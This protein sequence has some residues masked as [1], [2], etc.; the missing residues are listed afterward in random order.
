MT[1]ESSAV[2]SVQST[3]VPGASGLRFALLIAVFAMAGILAGVGAFTFFYAKGA[4]YLVDDPQACVNCHIMRD[5][6][7]SWSH[8][9]HKAVASCNSCH[10]P[11]DFIGKYATKLENGYAHSRAFTFQD[12]KEPIEMRPVS[13]NIVLNNCL[14][15][16]KEMVSPIT[17]LHTGSQ[18]TL[19]CIMCHRSVGHAA[20]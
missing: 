6:Y 14:D 8:S 19:D 11:H 12:F 10:V 17:A 5:Q 1:A 20:K 13:R 4:S 16:H 7:D 2:T 9:S 3:P 18:D 15:C